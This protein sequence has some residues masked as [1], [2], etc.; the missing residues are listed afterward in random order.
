MVGDEHNGDSMSVCGDEESDAVGRAERARLSRK[1][2]CRARARDAK[3]DAGRWASG[4]WVGRISSERASLRE[5]SEG[6]GGVE[7]DDEE[8]LEWVV[9]PNHRIIGGEDLRLIDIRELG[10]VCCG[11]YIPLQ[12]DE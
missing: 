8:A 6:D 9:L 10:M 7:G 3:K 12:S 1:E 11:R 2:G 5:A 4:G